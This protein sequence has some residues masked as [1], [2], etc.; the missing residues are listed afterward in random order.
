MTTEKQRE[1]NR[2]NAKKSTGPKTAA[3]SSRSRMNA[4]KHGLTASQITLYDEDPAEFAAF[5]R[6]LYEALK[7]EGVLEEFLV[8]QIACCGW[9]MQRA[10]RKEAGLYE[11]E[12]L[13]VEADFVRSEVALADRHE[14]G[15]STPPVPSEEVTAEMRQMIMDKRISA[16]T[17]M[18]INEQREAAGLGN[19]GSVFHR[20]SK[21]DP[22]GTLQ[23]YETGIERSFYRALH[24]L[25]RVQARRKGE[26]VAAPLAVDIANGN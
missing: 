8:E 25:E 18:Q 21:Q 2:R 22:I 7:P 3:G 16:G 24:N 23:R 13:A 10:C 15:L 6:G 5:H 26:M 1:A 9:R 11:A 14:E 17:R 20:L 4:L 19:I 12:E